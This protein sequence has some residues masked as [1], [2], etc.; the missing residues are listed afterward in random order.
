MKL[1]IVVFILSSLI[2]NSILIFVSSV[3]NSLNFKEKVYVLY[4]DISWWPLQLVVTITLGN[5]IYNAIFASFGT[6]TVKISYC[7]SLL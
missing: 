3:I 2:N 1:N 6:E 5:D 4:V 7:S